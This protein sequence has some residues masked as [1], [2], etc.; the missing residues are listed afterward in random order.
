MLH[1]WLLTCLSKLRAID[2]RYHPSD[3]HGG[4]KWPLY[5]GWQ[6]RHSV[7]SSY[8]RHVVGI[9]VLQVATIWR[10]KLNCVWKLLSVKLCIIRNTRSANNPRHTNWSD[11]HIQLTACSHKVYLQ[12]GGVVL[13]RV[14]WHHLTS[15]IVDRPRRWRVWKWTGVSI[16]IGRISPARFQTEVVIDG[17][18]SR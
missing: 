17:R 11:L 3:D 18:R 9:L 12:H 7:Y 14:R 4:P 16:R 13:V 8:C 6:W 10:R 2:Q 15:C 1:H 5:T